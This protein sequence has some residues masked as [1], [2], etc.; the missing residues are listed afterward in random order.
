MRLFWQ[1]QKQAIAQVQPGNP[2]NLFHD[3]AVRVLTEGL[4]EIGILKGEIDKLIEEENTNLFT[5][6]ALAI[7]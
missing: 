4:V 3:T 2:Y 1:T 6:T 7:G 5:C